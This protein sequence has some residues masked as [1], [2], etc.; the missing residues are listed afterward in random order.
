MQLIPGKLYRPIAPLYKNIKPNYALLFLEEKHDINEFYG[1]IYTFLA[2]SG[3]IL[4]FSYSQQIE[5]LT[6]ENST[7]YT[8]MF[9][10]IL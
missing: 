9:K 3:K 10:E 1:Y 8:T 4:K 7:K 2:P 5:T 6:D